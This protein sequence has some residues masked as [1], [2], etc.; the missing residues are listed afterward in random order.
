MSAVS[1]KKAPPLL[2]PEAHGRPEFSPL[3]EL[4]DPTISKDG[5]WYYVY[6][7]GQGIEARRSRDL[8][9]WEL[10]PPVFAD[11]VPAWAKQ[12]IGRAHV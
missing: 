4:P 9:N 11:P 10:L 7:T 6:A 8:V 2:P 12:K 3:W 1:K 5:D